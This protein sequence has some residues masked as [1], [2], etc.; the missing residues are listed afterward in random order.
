MMSTIPSVL[1]NR[2]EAGRAL[3]D[4]LSKRE[5][6]N[7]VVLALPRGGVPVA[8]EVAHALKAPLDLVMVRKLGAPGHAEYA[9][10]AVV[11]GEN[12]EFVLDQRAV[13]MTGASR[14]Y[15]ERSKQAALAEI[16]RRRAAY[17][18]E[19]QFPLAGCTA[20]LVDDGIATGSTAKAALI[21]VRRAKPAR[22][23]LAV[24]VAPADTLIDL[25]PLCDEIVCL[26]TPR[27]YYAVGAHYSD[28]GQTTDAE[29][30][31]LLRL[32]REQLQ[33]SHR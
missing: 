25:S 18:I 27:R 13:A 5:W 4:E 12:P 16:E 24:P 9:I 28:F 14:A 32:A 26:N 23:I 15:I 19:R 29:V 22:I 17:G 11:D 33:Q 1:A 30:M 20:I 6:Q 2:K 21:A 7:P 10:G 3:A 8:F 31:R